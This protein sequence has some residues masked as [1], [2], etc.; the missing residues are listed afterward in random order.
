M[1][2]QMYD[3]KAEASLV[4]ERRWNLDPGPASGG[5]SAGAGASHTESTS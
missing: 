3:W 1:Y 4:C 2:D 5:S